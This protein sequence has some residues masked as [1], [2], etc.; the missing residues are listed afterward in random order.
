MKKVSVIITTYNSAGYIEKAIRSIIDQKGAGSLFEMEVIVIDDHSSDN[1]VEILQRFPIRV[2]TSETNSGGP[3][4]GRNIG[5][6]LAQGDYI[7]HSDHDDLWHPDRIASLLPYLE[8]APIVTSGFEVENVI[9]NDPPRIIRMKSNDPYKLFTENETFLKKLTKSLDAQNTY[10]SSIIY[11]NQLKD[12]LFEEHFGKVDFD[13]ILRLFHRQ[14]SIEVNEVLYTRLKDGSNLSLDE[15]YRI[16]DTFYSL[17][18]IQE[19]YP[20]YPREVVIAHKKIY[21]SLARYYYFVGNMPQARRF[22][23]RS[24]FSLKTL[25]YFLSSYAGSSLVKKYFHI[26]D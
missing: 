3:N 5:L 17:M 23:K 15:K 25:A 20:E 6:R 4:R 9:Q 14:P 8:I 24:E 13:W 7:C 2:I 26:Y 22:L 18:S 12:V 10:L 21:G 1:T 11:R 19:Y 16:T